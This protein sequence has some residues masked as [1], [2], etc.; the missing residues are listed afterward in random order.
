MVPI[1]SVSAVASLCEMKKRVCSPVMKKPVSVMK[2]RVSSPVMKKPES[3][4]K[5]QTTHKE[6][7]KD[8]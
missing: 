4:M 2:K 3:E 6:A 7:T 1:G 8:Y 5:P